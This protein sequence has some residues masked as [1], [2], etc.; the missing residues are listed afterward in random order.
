GTPFAIQQMGVAPDIITTAKGISAG[1]APLG[2]AIVHDRI[3]K[4][5]L[6]HGTF[7]HGFT[8]VGSPIATAIGSRVLATYRDGDLFAQAAARG[9]RLRARL[10]ELATRH[11]IIGEVRGRGLMLGLEL[12][13]DRDT[14]R[15]FSCEAGVAEL[16]ARIAFE[17]GLIV[18]AAGEGATEI[19]RDQILLGPPFIISEVEIDELVTLL[20]DTLNVLEAAV[21]VPAG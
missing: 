4:V 21:S 12:V 7:N 8:N 3:F 11:P 2:A 18:Y 16:A 6:E 15:S 10:D 20:D 17:R 19:H 9:Q 5:F 1:Y 13:A 14:G